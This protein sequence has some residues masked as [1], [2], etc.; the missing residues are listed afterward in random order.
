MKP[1]FSRSDFVRKRRPSRFPK[2]TGE[3]A[4]R[5]AQ[6]PTHSYQTA[7][8]LLPVE[9]R[10]IPRR[11]SHPGRDRSARQ[12]RGAVGGQSYDIAFNLGRTSVRAP[13]ISVSLPQLG[14]RWISA[15]ITAAMVFLMYTCWNSAAF[16][17]SAAE[18]NGAERLTALEV[19]SAIGLAGEPIFKAVPA[20]IIRTLRNAYPELSAVR[21]RVGFPNRLRV[22]V[23]E[24]APVLAWQQDGAT[25]LIDSHGVP[26][27][28]RGEV[29]G[30]IQVLADQT[31]IPL[32]DAA[33]LPI[34]ER[35]YLDPAIVHA[36][37]IL[38]PYLPTG[39]PM[40]YN[41]TYGMGWQD[42]HGW[43][44]YFGQNA[45]DI[46]MKLVIYQAVTAAFTRQNIQPTLVS[47]EY[48][49]APFYK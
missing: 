6:K 22:D 20:E 7:S 39:I 8:L 12:G 5:P 4:A 1:S 14:P 49:D 30:L 19:N 17:V 24:R 18:L 38:A 13:A 2:K 42:P 26:F 15:V 25:L 16:T 47:V 34:Y 48:L 23:V 41:P 11:S 44:V 45:Q 36:M 32:E 40:T 31:P 3:T 35:P 43:F 28:A 27:P 10:A 33:D 29:S 21:V 37:T 46:Q 9:P